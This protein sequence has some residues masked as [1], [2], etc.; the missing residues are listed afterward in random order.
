MSLPLIW[1]DKINS[2]LL[3]D[4]IA[5]HGAEYC[6]TAEEINQMRDAINE[7]AVIQ[8]S[9][10]MGTAEPGDTPTG[11]GNRYWTAITPATYANHGDVEVDANSFAIIAVTAAGAWS[12][13][14]TTLDL[15][16]K[17]NV[18]D[19]SSN[20]NSTSATEALNL[21]G[22]KKLNDTKANL[23]VGKNRFNWQDPD[24]L[25][26]F[27]IGGGSNAI[28][29]DAASI[30]TGYIPVIAGEQI[31]SNK[32]SG[33]WANLYF[34][35]NKVKLSADYSNGALTMPAST[36]FLRKTVYLGGFTIQQI[37]IELGSTSTTFES[38]KLSIPV[39]ELGNAASIADLKLETYYKNLKANKDFSKNL[40]NKNDVNPTNGYLSGTNTINAN[41]GYRVSSFRPVLPSN[42]YTSSNTGL[43]GARNEYYDIDKN[44]ISD[45]GD[46][47]ITTP[48][49]CYFVRLSVG[50]TWLNIA[51]FELGATA[52]SYVAY[53]ENKTLDD[54]VATID[55]KIFNKLDKQVGKNKFNKNNLFVT[56][57]YLGT[58]GSVNANGSYRISH[59]MAVLPSTVYI[60]SNNGL[61]GARNAFYDINNNWIDDF[62]DGSITTPSNCYFVRLSVGTTWLNTAQFELGATATSYESYTELAFIQN[63]LDNTPDRTPEVI[64]PKKLYFIKNKQNS[65][66]HENVLLKNLSDAATLFMDKGND[67]NRQTTFTFTAAATN[68]DLFTQIVRNFKLGKTKTIKYDV[69]DPATNAGKTVNV[70]HIGDSF[71]DI[72]SWVKECKVI[73]TAQGVNYNQ[74]GIA[75]D[76]TYKAEGLSGGR[77]ANTFLDTSSGVARI[78]NVTGVTT[79]PST[80]YPGRKYEDSNGNFWTVRGGKIDGSGNGKLVVTK[81]NAVNGDFA[82][83]PSSGTLTKRTEAWGGMGEGDSIINYTSPVAAYFNPFINPSTGV[84]DI[85][86]YISFWSFSTPDIVIFQFTWNDLVLWATDLQVSTLVAQFKTACDHVH[87]AFPSAKVILSIEPYGSVNGNLDWNGKK[88]SVLKFTEA[89]LIQFEDDIAYNT[90]VKIAPSYAF[91]DLVNGYSGGGTVVPCDRYPLITE[92][93]GGDGVH[94][95]T[96]MLQIADCIAPIISAII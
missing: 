34:D 42:Q 18:S 73:L 21:A 49:N 50:T 22:A 82:T 3:A 80:T 72:G 78:V 29:A 53:T 28:E 36:K 58:D 35:A 47:S 26:G 91:V 59:F 40:F 27:R 9:T 46:G 92:V 32:N 74:L 94:P 61:G 83:F 75:G 71:T 56:P 30:V 16:G 89:M 25:V 87:A 17:L 85:A 11:T 69:I 57:A 4:F 90:W 52:T 63:I 31:I 5:K 70:L 8:Q 15:T 19:L 84:L 13:S 37:Q 39:S 76:S 38:Y 48:S 33:G 41:S 66:Y 1:A 43:G 45:F 55:T 86:N 14:Q 2:P 93:S 54:T 81:D 79:K 20:L 23:T 6:M 24:V 62:G 77:L 65:I 7:M 44:L 12:I 64:L 10:Y 96:G 60:S 67:Y 88:Y 51:Q 95:V 68:Q